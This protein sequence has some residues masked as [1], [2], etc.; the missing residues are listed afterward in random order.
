MS[1]GAVAIE[2][3]EARRSCA[4]FDAL[5]Y[6]L[7]RDDPSWVAPLRSR[8]S[9]RW[10]PRRNP[11]LRA[12]RVG[13]FL[14]RRDGRPVGRIAAVVDRGFS[15]R[16]EPASGFFGFFECERDPEAAVAL[17]NAAERFLQQEGVRLVLGPINLSFHNEVGLL[18]EG[19]DS[20]P[21]LLSPYNPPYYE[22]LL[23][24]GK[25][26]ART[27]YHAYLWTPASRHTEAVERILQRAQRGTEIRLRYVDRKRWEEECRTLHEL[28]NASFADVWGFV[29]MTWEEFQ[30]EA[31]SF[32]DFL[33][34]ELIILAEE[35]SDA[36]GFSVTLPDVNAALA[37]LKGRLLPFGWLRLLTRIPRIRTARHILLGVRPDH[38][39]RGVA[40]RLAHAT[41]ESARAG[42]LARA[43]L[44]LVHSANRPILH[45][46]E[47]FGCPPIKTYRLY[48]K[49]IA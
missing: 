23:H 39:A 47:A 17:L 48:E 5:P 11:A 3:V 37:G 24:D 22:G 2:P 8:E 13:R 12:R 34:P 9:E 43:E 14:A 44:S 45:I 42:N 26:S 36:V 33:R 16:W 38:V 7:Y 19:F 1:R 25:Y 41:V 46:I 10:D 27:D 49:T 21:M 35:G 6:R 40:A 31:E 29:P 18:V 20:S 30:S 32:R 28:Y 4:E 15:D